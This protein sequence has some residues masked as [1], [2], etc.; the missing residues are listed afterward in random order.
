MAISCISGSMCNRSSKQE[1][2]WAYNKK[3]AFLWNSNAIYYY[4]SCFFNCIYSMRQIQYFLLIFT[5]FFGPISSC[6][7]VDDMKRDMVYYFK[8]QDIK[9]HYKISSMA[10]L[11]SNKLIFSGC[12]SEDSCSIYELD[13]HTKL[14]SQTYPIDFIKY[15][16]TLEEIFLSDKYKVW[17]GNDFVFR[18]NNN[19]KISNRWRISDLRSSSSSQMKVDGKGN[20]WIA[21]QYEPGLKVFDGLKWDTHFEEEVIMFICIDLDGNIYASNLPK[22]GEKGVLMKYDYPNWD[23]LY[24]CTEENLWVS[25]MDIDN[26]GNLYFGILSRDHVG[27][28]YGGGIIKYDGVSF[29][30][31]TIQNSELPGNSVVDIFVN[32]NNSIWIGTYN[33]GFAKFVSDYTWENFTDIDLINENIEHIIESDEDKVYFSIQWF[34]LGSMKI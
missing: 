7:K 4:R 33:A 19:I 3:F 14:I 26:F 13:L 20:L 28:N 6:E 10:L 9:T 23:S 12:N 34:G 18:Y 8:Q 17:K 22:P 1:R 16:S 30:K 24:T 29:E 2:L 21:E 27:I 5:I 32:K 31:Y 11:D 25:C 15:D